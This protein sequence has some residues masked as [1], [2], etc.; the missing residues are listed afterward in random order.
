VLLA[1]VGPR[2][3]GAVGRHF[4]DDPVDNR[5][6]NL[7]WGTRLDNAADRLRNGRYARGEDKP[8]HRLTAQQA[9]EIRSDP[10]PSRV[11]GAEYGVSHTAVLRIRRNE[12][13]VA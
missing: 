4:N 12:R 13:W 3:D 1:F 10:R 2:P 5:P 9:I 6:E 11:V 7:A 8:G